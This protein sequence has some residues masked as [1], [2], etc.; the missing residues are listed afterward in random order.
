MPSG[1][2]PGTLCAE[3]TLAGRLKVKWVQAE[4]SQGVC[5]GVPLGASGAE[6]GTDQET[7]DGPGR[8]TPAR[9][10]ELRHGMGSSFLGY[11]AQE[12]PG[13]AA[14]AEVGMGQGVPGC[15]VPGVTRQL[16]H[17]GG[18]SLGCSGMLCI[19]DGWS[20]SER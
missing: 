12:H 11:S 6:A 10:L 4:M 3:G 5:T 7:L 18:G 9:W 17:S 20:C 16:W 8:G 15:F 2:G 14:G 13:G 1:G 19:C